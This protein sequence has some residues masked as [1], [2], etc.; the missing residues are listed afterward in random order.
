MTDAPA[1][2]VSLRGVVRRFEGRPVLAGVDLDAADGRL[3]VL[4]GR[5]GA[6]K[7]TLLR[8]VA[9]LDAPDEG[10]IEVGGRVVADPVVR[11][12]AERRGVGMVFQSLELWPHM[13]V[14]ENVAFGLPGRPRGRAALAHARVREVC[15]QV[16][17]PEALHRRRPPTLSGGERQRAAIAR[18]LAPSP[19]VLLYDEP[20]ANLDPERRAEIRRLVRRLRA[21]TACTV[22]YVTHDA[23]EALEM[24]DAVAVL[25]A[26]RVVDGG[27]PEQVYAHPRTLASARALGAVS[28]VPARAVA[29]GFETAF[30][31]FPAPG[32]AASHPPAASAQVAV[33]RPEQVGP[34]TSGV[35]AEIL[36]AHPVAG[37]YAF[38]ARLAPSGALV[39]G[40]SG[41]RLA[42]GATVRLALAGSPAFVPAERGS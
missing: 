9:G 38:S 27:T 28:E 25:E 35:A 36:D 7:S 19:R 18:A 13:T 21:E 5:S 12:P 3:L 33:L 34:A 24:G 41:S 31:A 2:P 10:R 16:G 39:V 30:G 26:G 40:R 29:G 22:L 17:L 6:G 8:L 14:A 42:T 20:L 23:A 32:A 15:A 4:L 1:V 11:V 37:G